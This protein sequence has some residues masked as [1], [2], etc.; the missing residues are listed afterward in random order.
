MSLEK[1]KEFFKGTEMDGKIIELEKSS[2]TVELAAEALSCDG[3]TIAKTLSFLADG[4]PVVIVVS[5]KSKIDNAK[6]KKKF[7]VKAKMIPADSVE[8]ITGH[9]PGGVCPFALNDGVKVFLDES[10]RQHDF[11]FPAAGTD[12]SA[13]K[14]TIGQL[15]KFSNSAEWIDVTKKSAD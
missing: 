10:L 14:M 13:I 7:G 3:D 11:V 15:E 2:A 12:S 9:A 8:K 5:G 1:V 6:Y 4:I